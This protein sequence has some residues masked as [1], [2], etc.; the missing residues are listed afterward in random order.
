MES[1]GDEGSGGEE[2]GDELEALQASALAVQQFS[3]AQTGVGPAGGPGAAAGAAA[4][5]AAVSPAA[6]QACLE[7]LPDVGPAALSEVVLGATDA[8]LLRRGP[9]A[10]AS[11]AH[12]R[13][14]T[15]TPRRGTDMGWL[16]VLCI[17]WLV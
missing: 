7:P 12:G 1:A 8:D 6:A 9:G 2:S 17:L 15:R 4:S 16:F 13:R 14:M 11:G 10:R 3:Q 5:S